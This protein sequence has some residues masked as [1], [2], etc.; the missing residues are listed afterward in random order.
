VKQQ[1]PSVARG[2]VF[3]LTPIPETSSGQALSINLIRPAGTF[4]NLTCPLGILSK[5]RGEMEYFSIWRR[6]NA[7]A[8]FGEG[9]MQTATPRLKKA[10]DERAFLWL[11]S[12][13]GTKQSSDL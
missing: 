3:C 1:A 12:L 9:G 11:L 2:F 5:W 7:I 4:S 6:E 10:R 13:R 8:L